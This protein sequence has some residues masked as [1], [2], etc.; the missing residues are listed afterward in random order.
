MKMDK[1]KTPVLCIC[2]IGLRLVYR[3]FG[4][5]VYLRIWLKMYLEN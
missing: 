3:K 5:I 1:L 2:L 4:K